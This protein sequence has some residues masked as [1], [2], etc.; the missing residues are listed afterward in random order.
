MTKAECEQETIIMGS[1]LEN[2]TLVKLAP[3]S[4]LTLLRGRE[5]ILEATHCHPYAWLTRREVVPCSSWAN[6]ADCTEERSAVLER[7]S[8]VLRKEV[9]YALER[10]SAAFACQLCA[11]CIAAAREDFE[12]GRRVIWDNLPTYFGLPS[13]SDLKGF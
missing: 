12:R 11:A 4:Q 5:S 9:F 7:Y 13:W 2:G 8:S 3:S 6:P 1:Q 10:W